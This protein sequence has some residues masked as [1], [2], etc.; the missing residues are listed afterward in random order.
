MNKGQHT[1]K[2]AS[3]L[4][5]KNI[6]LGTLCVS[7]ILFSAFIML[8]FGF[9]RTLFSLRRIN[10]APVYEF[11]LRHDYGFD[12]Y[13]KVGAATEKELVDFF[14]GRRKP[15]KNPAFPGSGCS[16]FLAKTP[17]GD[18][19]L[20]RNFDWH[21]AL[22]A[23]MHSRSKKTGKCIG[24]TNLNYSGIEKLTDNLFDPERRK[25]HAAPYMTL[26]GMNE[27][28]LAAAIF[29][30]KGSQSSIDPA[31]ITLWDITI[32]RA[33][34]DHAT[35]TREAIDFLSRYNVAYNPEWP[36]QY[37]VADA[38]GNSAIIE[39]VKGEMKVLENTGPTQVCTNFIIYDNPSLTGFG[40][41]RYRTIAR[42]LENQGG[43]IATE[44]AIRLLKENV[45]HNQG[46]W[47]AVY[48][49]TKKTVTAVFAGD[50][51]TEFVRKIE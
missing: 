40:D 4:T 46:Q 33:I 5:R 15:V 3:R 9:Y 1:P 32:I 25:L 42:Q 6:L 51:A 11:T 22:P 35:T 39:F 8:N 47:S 12:S 18:I 45:I 37:M 27:H 2:K 23:I 28:G 49:L 41:Y 48:N 44:D 31:K 26:D 10:P 17:E 29:T 24:L 38:A 7:I 50:Y 13:L 16:A 34:L 19:I 30:A 14:L 36:S 43:V 21:T 20:G